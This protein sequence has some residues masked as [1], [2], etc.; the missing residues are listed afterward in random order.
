MKGIAANTLARGC[1]L[2]K[3]REGDGFLCSSAP[4]LIKIIMPVP[5]SQLNLDPFVLSAVLAVF[6]ALHFLSITV[7][8]LLTFILSVP[9]F[10]VNIKQ[11][12]A[13]LQLAVGQ[14]HA[15]LLKSNSCSKK[16]FCSSIPLHCS[17]CRGL[18]IFSL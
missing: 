13:Y 15:P 6:A 16:L 5:L 14:G 7:S 17:S 12:F 8:L 3:G 11:V 1:R 2:Q 18:M 10:P 9:F 4:T